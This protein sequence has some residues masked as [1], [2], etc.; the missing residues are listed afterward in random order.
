MIENEYILTVVVPAY[1]SEAYIERNI[2]SFLKTKSAGDNIFELLIIDDGSVDDTPQ[3]LDSY[4]DK[5]PQLIHVIHKENGGHG[6]GINAGIKH[7]QGKY[8]KVVDSDDWV[9]PE[10]FDKLVFTLQNSDE[11][12]VASN[13]LWTREKDGKHFSY[14]REFKDPFKGVIY[15]KP[16]DFKDIPRTTY[17]KMHAMTIKTSILRDNNI[18]IDEHCFYV[19]CEYILFPIPF[20][21][22][23]KFIDEDVYCYLLGRAGQSMDLGKMNR[24]EA[25]Y[26]RVLQSLLRFY[27]NL[28]PVKNAGC[29]PYITTAI[30]R[31]YAGYIK[32][33][34]SF[35]AS[36][37]NKQRLIATEHELKNR[38]NAIYKANINKPIKALRL[39]G[40]LLYNMAAKKVSHPKRAGYGKARKESN[41]ETSDRN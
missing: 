8:F 3:I 41:E 38:Y 22:T 6:S 28:D 16:Y 26:C 10:A 12:I 32:I 34:L 39:S 2:R 5:Y 30:G 4:A 20:V 11:D 19:D 23:V 40:Y 1:N 15:G 7:A 31:I 27:D 21:R 9:R 25:Q 35:P 13:Y 33:M 29:I 14:E 17:I 18:H 37:E 36:P 24:N